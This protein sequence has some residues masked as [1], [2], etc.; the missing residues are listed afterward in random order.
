MLTGIHNTSTSM[1]ICSPIYTYKRVSIYT[2]SAYVCVYAH[3]LGLF[4]IENYYNSFCLVF[5]FLRV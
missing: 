5:A 2:L 3:I 4:C 1:L